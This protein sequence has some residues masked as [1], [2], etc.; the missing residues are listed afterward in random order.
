MKYGYSIIAAALVVLAACDGSTTPGGTG[1]VAI[2]F[3]TSAG[4]N[5]SASVQISGDPALAS[6]LTLTGTNGTLVIQ[7]IRLI[8]SRLELKQAE[9]TTCTGENETETSG[10]SGHDDKE[11]GE[12]EAND[13]EREHDAEC[14]EFEG[15]P[16]IVDLPLTG[17]TSIATD[18]VPA[19]TYTA[20]S[21]RVKN[22]DIDDDDDSGERANTASV[23]TQMRTFYPNFP[24]SAS[25]VVKGTFNGTPFTTYVRSEMRIE[26]KLD[27]PLTVPG[28]KAIQVLLDPTAWF[29][30]GT[31]VVDLSA[32]NGRI[33][34]LGS[35]FRN[36]VRSANRRHDG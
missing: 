12:N 13:T 35:S 6:D 9:G 8:V 14:D 29:K 33:L 2:R 3:G 7:D 31:Q 21:F 23:L 10:R 36:G 16:F 1:A 32:F 22:L 19:G 25:M 5:A 11:L 28:D 34:D 24:S 4:S 26:Q 15:G 20:F 17:T 27:A 30:N 18:N